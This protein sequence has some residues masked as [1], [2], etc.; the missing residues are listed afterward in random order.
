MFFGQLHVR[1][2]WRIEIQK[3][4][5]DLG[6]EQVVAQKE[7]DSQGNG[8]HWPAMAEEEADISFHPLARQHDSAAL[9]L[10]F[11]LCGFDACHS[12]ERSDEESP[13]GRTVRDS[14]PP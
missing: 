3:V 4:H 6:L 1:M 5:L 14:S 9:L 11:R 7:G 13:I 2:T 10:V 8:K 12:E